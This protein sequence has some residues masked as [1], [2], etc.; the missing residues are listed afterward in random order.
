MDIHQPI[1]LVDTA[2]EEYAADY[3]NLLNDGTDYERRTEFGLLQTQQK[4]NEYNLKRFRL[5]ALPTLSIFGN[6]GYNYATEQFD[7]LF[8]FRKNYIFSSLYGLTL[9][10]P[11]FRG[12]QRTNQVREARLNIEKTR[13]SIDNVK[14]TIDFQSAQSKTVLKNSILQ[15]QAQERNTELSNTVLG[16]ARTKYKEGVGSNL[17]VTQAQTDYLQSQNN[18]FQSLLDVMN[19]QVELEKAL[20]LLLN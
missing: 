12:F 6:M 19:A 1:V 7:E 3:E 15:M 13:N 11:L 9:N 14:L 4:L 2:I 18:Y 5:A 20:G 17:E 8:K 10:V 16:L